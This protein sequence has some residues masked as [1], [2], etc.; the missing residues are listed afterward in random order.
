[1]MWCHGSKQQNSGQ[2][3][4]V[5][6]IHKEFHYFSTVRLKKTLGKEQAISLALLYFFKAGKKI[7]YSE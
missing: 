2:W 4:H 1:M 6:I 5:F 7:G 3:E